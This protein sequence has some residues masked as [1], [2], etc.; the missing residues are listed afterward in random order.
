MAQAGA[1]ALT[2]H[3]RRLQGGWKVS[4]SE[5]YK[6]LVVPNGNASQPFHRWFHL[7]EAYS[8]QL[9]P[10]LI[11]DSDYSPTEHL[12]VFDPYSGSGTTL[13]SALDLAAEH[14]I[15]AEVRGIERNPFL[16]ELSRAKVYGRIAGRD[17]AKSFE[18]ALD[19]VADAF[20]ESKGTPL[21][22]PSQSTLQNETYFPRA[23]VEDLVAIRYAIDQ[24][25][26]GYTRTLLRVSLAAA[27]ENCG[28]LRRDGRA[29]RF[30]PSRQPKDAW[31]SF[32]ERAAA[33]LQDLVLSEP[34]TS[35]GDVLLGDGRE[36]SESAARYDW[37]VFSPPY[38]NNIDYTEVYKTE[39]WVLGCYESSEEMRAQRQLTVRS[40]P[41][42]RFN[43][44]YS[45]MDHAESAQVVSVIEP[46]L[47]AVPSDRYSSGRIELIKG[48]A[49]DMM[50]TLQQCR[51]NISANGRLAFIVGNSSH[52]SGEDSFVIAA[53]VIMSS[54]AELVGWRVE[55]LRVARQLS[56]RS[57][58]N[59]FL[60]ESVVILAPN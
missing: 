18:V 59:E 33:M 38:P 22:V 34:L 48:Y 43:R 20:R 56:R 21:P 26:D 52:G 36:G 29:L 37:I 19:A 27:V 9:L 53:D 58:D 32:S 25:S 60:R 45:F 24:C 31:S 10:R 3:Y 40:H 50:L 5:A 30:A 17:A 16:W 7:K 39:A 1:S 4:Q 11:A 54:L 8:S 15:H 12:A 46:I 55:E 2:S 44:E 57:S 23:N 41:S 14:G 49:D 51:H 47:E 28:R 35:D 42:V 13:L 6:R